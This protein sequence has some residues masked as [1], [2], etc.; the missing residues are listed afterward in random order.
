MSK[1]HRVSVKIG[2]DTLKFRTGESREILKEK[3]SIPL[4][5][6]Q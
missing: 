2:S 4:L 1:I 3:S 5:D 6:L